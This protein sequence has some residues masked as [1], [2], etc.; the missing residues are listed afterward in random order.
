MWRRAMD[1]PLAIVLAVIIHLAAAAL[2]V[3]SFDWALPTFESNEA[4]VEIVQ[5]TVVDE[6]KVQ[7]EIQRQENQERIKRAEEEG[8]SNLTCSY[9]RIGLGYTALWQD[10]GEIPPSAPDSGM[11]KPVML[12]GSSLACDTRVKWFQAFQRYVDAPHFSFD[13]PILPLDS[14]LDPD[15]RSR[16]MKYTVAQLHGLVRFMERTLDRKMD[17]GRLDELVRRG[18]KTYGLFHEAFMLAGKAVPCP[19]PGGPCYGR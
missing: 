16:Y 17:W 2:L 9:A 7:A 15:V 10:T 11:F 19:M 8:F 1:L 18:Q 3:L 13:T 14:A 6:E 12:V 4:E 5:A